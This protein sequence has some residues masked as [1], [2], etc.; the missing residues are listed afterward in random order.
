[1]QNQ[2]S[3]VAQPAQMASDEINAD[4]FVDDGRIP[5]AGVT[6]SP[7]PCVAISITAAPLR[8]IPIENTPSPPLYMLSPV[9]LRN[10]LEAASASSTKETPPNSNTSFPSTESKITG[11]WKRREERWQRQREERQQRQ[12]EEQ[13]RRYRI[14]LRDEQE[15]TRIL[16][17]ASEPLFLDADS[18]RIPTCLLRIGHAMQILSYLF[19]PVFPA[20]IYVLVSSGPSTAWAI[21]LGM[22]IVLILH[23]A[24]DFAFCRGGSRLYPRR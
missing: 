21:L 19:I 11:E 15:T 7:S 4:S 17:A 16:L 1:M 12:R 13:R 3:A 14:Q 5:S 23:L 18:R 10:V 6:A 2:Y 8:A 9:T 20:S 22:A 24:L